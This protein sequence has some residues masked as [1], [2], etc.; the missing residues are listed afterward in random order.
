MEMTTNLKKAAK[1]DEDQTQPGLYVRDEVLELLGEY[2]SEAQDGVLSVPLIVM[3]MEMALALEGH[4][5]L[6][7]ASEL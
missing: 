7:S 6:K 2:R 4:E 1:R 3:E 5:V